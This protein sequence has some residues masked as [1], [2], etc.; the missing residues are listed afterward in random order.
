[1]IFEMVPSHSCS[2][3]PRSSSTN[4]KDSLSY[5]EAGVN[6]AAGSKLVAKIK[7][8]A[9]S[10]ERDGCLSSLGSFAALFH[11]KPAG[12]QDLVLVSSTDGVGTKLK[13]GLLL[14][15]AF[16]LLLSL[17]QLVRNLWYCTMEQIAMSVHLQ[18]VSGLCCCC[19]E[20]LLCLCPFTGCV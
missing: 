10:T 9:K 14:L 17:L 20:Q 16:S 8:L 12:Y 3:C 19:V 11:T 2:P 7:P 1:M 18:A 5:K 6:I 15:C 13:V 4:T